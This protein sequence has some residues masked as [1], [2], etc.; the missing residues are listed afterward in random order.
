[1]TEGG[2]RVVSGAAAREGRLDLVV[3]ALDPNWTRSQVARWIREGRVSVNQRRTSRPGEVVP[4]GA[5]LQV[6]VPD[7]LPSSVAAQDLPLTVVYED[8]DLA[9]IDKAAGMVVHPAPGHADGTLVNALLHHLDDLSGV[10]GEER[11]GIVHRLDRGTSGLLV[12]AKHDLAHRAL[13]RQFAEH[14]AGRRYVAVVHDPP[15]DEAGTE[16]STLGRHPR[17]RHRM[18]SVD[19]GR[20]AVTH[21]QVIA[22]VGAVG[23]VTCRLE[24]GRTHQ[25]RVHLA[26]RGAP[27]VG[28]GLYGRADRTL[29]ARL[30]GL[31]DPSGERPLLHAW[32]LRF[33]HPTTGAE[34]EFFAPPPPDLQ[35]VLDALQVPWTGRD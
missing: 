2:G 25:I 35:R 11:P 23:V 27:L 22:R 5:A 17:D 10:G 26:E 31:V 19:G 6:E 7:P 1:M 14:T 4:A 24:T 12:V 20:A 32:S 8:E 28:D 29:P 13:S 18:A 33:E 34:R 15:R 3:T 9:V 16:R 21:W 30:R